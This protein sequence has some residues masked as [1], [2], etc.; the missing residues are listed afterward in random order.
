MCLLNSCSFVEGFDRNKLCMLTEWA[1]LSFFV[2]SISHASI[3]SIF[4]EQSSARLEW[5]YFKPVWLHAA[6]AEM[7]WIS[8]KYAGWSCAWCLSNVDAWCQESQPRWSYRGPPAAAAASDLGKLSC[9]CPCHCCAISLFRTINQI[10]NT[11]RDA[12]AAA[13]PFYLV[14]GS[15]QGSVEK[16][17]SYELAM[18]LTD[19]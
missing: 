11:Y 6:A 14:T 15:L 2:T 7:I 10:F 3:P 13:I 19:T 16:K 9:S 1:S 8:P 4:G 12:A 5:P 17:V 18:A